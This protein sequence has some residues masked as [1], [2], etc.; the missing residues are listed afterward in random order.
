M[1]TSQAHTDHHRPRAESQPERNAERRGWRNGT[2]P[3]RLKTRVGTVELRIPK[4][5]AGQFQSSL[6]ERYQRSEKALVAALTTM[7]IQG[8]STRRVTKMVGQLCG[9]LCPLRR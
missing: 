9:V 7:Y 8:V 4:D 2:K 3:W 1:A 5:R 6:F